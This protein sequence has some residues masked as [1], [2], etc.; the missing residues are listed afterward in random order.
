M[1][2]AKD[3]EIF[4][5]PEEVVTPPPRSGVGSVRRILP[6]LSP[7]DELH[8]ATGLVWGLGM[9]EFSPAGKCPT[10]HPAA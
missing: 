10:D 8:S 4:V 7:F 9:E 2:M 6:F 5:A 3:Q 1:G